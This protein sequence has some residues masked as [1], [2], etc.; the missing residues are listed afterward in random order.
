MDM[1]KYIKALKIEERIP[2]YER[3]HI[4]NMGYEGF[5]KWANIRGLISTSD[6]IE[7]FSLKDITTEEINN[8]LKEI[9]DKE[10]SIIAKAF[11]TMEWF[12]NYSM[13]LNRYA[14]LSNK[15]EYMVLLVRKI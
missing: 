9:D 5:Q 6:I 1:K 3:N 8:A 4:Y 13:A 7:L 10:I 2:V 12:E 14:Q 11:A 15:I